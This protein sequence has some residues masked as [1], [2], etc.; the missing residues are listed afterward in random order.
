MTTDS[1]DSDLLFTEGWTGCRE[2]HFALV[3]KTEDRDP[4]TKN[5]PTLDYK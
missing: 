4:T 1:Y 2:M 3:Y 5:P